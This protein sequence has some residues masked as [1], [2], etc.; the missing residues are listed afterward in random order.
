M[1]TYPLT[2][3]TLEEAQQLQFKLVDAITK[4]FSGTDILSYGDLGVVKGLNQPSVTKKV[5][6][7]LADFFNVE[8][9]LLVRG[10]GTNAIRLGLHALLNSGQT[11]LVHDAP[12]YPTTKV[13]ID[14]L[15]LQTI[16]A[17]FND[18]KIVQ[19]CLK[20]HQI[21][22]VLI[23]VTRQKL[24][25]SYDLETLITWIKELAPTIN[26]ITDDN[27]AA[28][29]TKGIGAELGATLSCFSTFKLLGPEGIG[30]IA[31]KREY[32]EKLKAENY[33]GG[34]QVQGYESL[35]VLRGMVYA[36][37]SLAISANVGTELCRRLNEG[38]VKGV[39]GAYIANAQ[40]RVVI[41]TLEEPIAKDVIE[42]AC[43]LGALGHPVGAESKYEFCPLI[44]RVS[45]T[46]RQENPQAESTMLRI[47][48]NRAGVDTIIRILSQAMNQ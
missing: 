22:A 13:S 29:K 5:E 8:A 47:N 2:S 38:E 45:S 26:I 14:M 39:K 1:M 41:V 11:V 16:K 21:D 10:A 3:L 25:D 30:C 9:T 40:S 46:F 31:G 12:I 36:P 34:G 24:N 17:D 27:Y 28:L 19:E 32:I 33:S 7:V 23:Q 18:K 4:Y 42:T 20:K 43:Q 48:P 15:G 35:E 37:V 44:Y 6:T